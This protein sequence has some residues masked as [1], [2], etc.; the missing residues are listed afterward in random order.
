M[1]VRQAVLDIRNDEIAADL[2]ELD[3]LRGE[4]RERQAAAQEEAVVEA[5][6]AQADAEAALEDVKSAVS[7][8]TQFVSALKKGLEVDAAAL[9]A[10]RATDPAR[11]DQ[12]ERLQAELT[13]AR[14]RRGQAVRGRPR[15]DRRRGAAQGPT[16][17]LEVPGPGP[18][19][20]HRLVGRTAREAAPTRAPT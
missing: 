20:L 2:T 9:E 11:A 4:L 15:G 14:S 17:D 13:P 6:A 16:G 5:E 1:S 18:R 3:E 10:L 8:Q 19:E 12:L 7:Q